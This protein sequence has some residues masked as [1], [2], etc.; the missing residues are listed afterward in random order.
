MQM[1]FTHRPVVPGVH[2]IYTVDPTLTYCGS[3]P[4][5]ESEGEGEQLNIIVG[6]FLRLLY[7]SA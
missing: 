1:F 4:R 2:L 3:I 6:P 7:N 5:W